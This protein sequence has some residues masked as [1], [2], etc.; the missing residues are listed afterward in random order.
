MGQLGKLYLFRTLL[1]VS[2][3][4]VDEH[5]PVV[6]K[7]LTAAVFL[8]NLF[9]GFQYLSGTAVIPLEYNCPESRYGSNLAIDVFDLSFCRV[10]KSVLYRAFLNF[11]YQ[12]LQR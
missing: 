2:L 3:H 10:I 8:I 6:K 12:G 11:Y 9:G 4:F 7:L 1:L 5:L